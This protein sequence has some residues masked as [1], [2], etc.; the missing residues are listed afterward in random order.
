MTILTDDRPARY[1]AD[2]YRFDVAPIPFAEFRAELLALYE[3]PLRAKGTY[4]KMRQAVDIA[5][6]FI[7]DGTTAD[8]TP[9]LVA[10]FVG[11]RPPELSP[12]TTA[13]LLRS[14]RT[15]CSYAKARGYVRNSPF[16]ARR[17]WVRASRPRRRRHHGR[18]EI[19]RVLDL[20]RL[21][22]HRRRPGAERWRARRIYALAATV[23]YTGCR[24]M[25]AIRLRVEDLDIP[26]RIIMITPHGDQRLKTL[27]A[28]QPVP[29]AAP[30][31]AILADWLAH[32]E[33]ESRLTPTAPPPARAD[34]PAPGSGWLFPGVERLGPWTGGPP[35]EKALDQLKAAGRRAGVEGFTFLS[36]RHSWATHAEFWG[37]SP[38]MIQRVLRHTTAQTQQH[39]RH[40]DAANLRAIAGAI[41]FGA[42]DATAGGTDAPC[43][44]PGLSRL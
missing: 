42:A 37:F 22:I 33:E 15:A 19:A 29:M 21:D 24:K 14:L 43:D 20:L 44:G 12:N 1:V 6:E 4:D 34:R 39:Y 16:D 2:P 17:E 18:E 28:E 31:A 5:G 25:E 8:L 36:L 30:L 41:D 10:R 7:G 23:A 9:A 3:P 40:A 32:L 11:S 35:G 38:A 13:A 27:A 26:G